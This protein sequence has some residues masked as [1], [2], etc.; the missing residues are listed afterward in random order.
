MTCD[1]PVVGS[2]SAATRDIAET[3][4]RKTSNRFA[5]SSGD[6]IVRPV[7]LASGVRQRSNQACAKDVVADLNCCGCLLRD[8]RREI[9]EGYENIRPYAN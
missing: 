6:I 9:T 5:L 2:H 7:V 8:F 3:V 4:S 1:A